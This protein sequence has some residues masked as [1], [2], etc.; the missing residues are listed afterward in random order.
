M[1][2]E[3]AGGRGLKPVSLLDLDGV[4]W[5]S[6]NLKGRARV[7]LGAHSGPERDGCARFVVD[8]PAGRVRIESVRFGFDAAGELER[9]NKVAAPSHIAAAYERRVLVER[10]KRELALP[11][12]A[13]PTHGK[14]SG[15]LER[16]ADAARGAANAVVVS[17]DAVYVVGLQGP[18]AAQAQTI[19][20]CEVALT[21]AGAGVRM[22]LAPR[23]LS[24]VAVR[25]RHDKGLER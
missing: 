5:L 1:L 15:K 21:R 4:G 7:F 24:L 17:R 19:L 16:L 12:K 6:S 11:V 10:L 13:I 2:L 25:E 8:D 18:Q 3:R 23:E 22:A 14:I 20:G 9:L